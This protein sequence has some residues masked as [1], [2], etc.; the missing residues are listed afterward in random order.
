MQRHMNYVCLGGG[1]EVGSDG[2]E[3]E[4]Q[5]WV[6]YQNYKLYTKNI[7]GILHVTNDKMEV[8]M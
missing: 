7:S 8:G 1:V 3:V 6:P 4:R 2:S 5:T